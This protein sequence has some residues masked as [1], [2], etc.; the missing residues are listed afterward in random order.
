VATQN[1]V[2]YEGTYPLPE[3]Q[4][5]RFLLR[6]GFGYPD[7]AAEWEVLS[8]RLERQRDEL[9]LRPVVDRETLLAMQQ[10][11]ETVH[12]EES[13][14]YYIVDLVTATRSHASV[15][16]GASPRGSLALV[17]A[18]RARAVLAGRDFVTPEDVKA[19]A[20]A[21]LGHRVVLKPAQWVRGV[22]GDAV[23]REVLGQ[24]PTPAAEDLAVLR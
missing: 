13:V 24:V 4:L 11:I 15:Q 2:E 3:A 10:S 8:R 5:D 12:V 6:V 20:V 9:V 22:T 21:A 23:V 14:G 1:P 7:R 18:G 19:V 17:M 16:V